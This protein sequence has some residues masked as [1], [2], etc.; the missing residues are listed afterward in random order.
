MIADR[1]ALLKNKIMNAK[2]EQFASRLR[3]ERA[4]LGLTQFQLCT[5]GGVSKSTQVAYEL[6]PRLPDLLYIDSVTS[7]GID[8]IF[9]LTGL[10]S[11]QFAAKRFNW[12]L[13]KEIIGAIARFQSERNVFIP[14]EKLADLTHLLYV[15]FI[16][17]GRIE[18]ESLARALSLVT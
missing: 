13:H 10:T 8:P 5:A 18:K 15:Q 12:E 3:S 7:V 17:D 4:R 2:I 16:E 14:P 1:Q 6:G 9:V 11:K